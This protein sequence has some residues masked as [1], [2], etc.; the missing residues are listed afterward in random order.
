MKREITL[1]CIPYAGAGFNAYG[2]L[3]RYFSARVAP[4]TLE[5]PGRGMRMVEDLIDDIGALVEDY[6]SRLPA[7]YPGGYALYGHSLGAILACLLAKRI[8]SAGLPAPLRLIV[9]GMNSPSRQRIERKRSELPRE[10]LIAALK[11]YGGTPEEV[12]QDE[13]L[14]DFVEPILRAD[15][16]TLDNF[17]YTPNAP[18]KTPISVAYGTGDKNTEWASLERWKDETAS[19]CDFLEFDGGHFFIFERARE[20]AAYVESK[21]GL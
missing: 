20:F 3:E 17:N 6:F 13:G 15:F 8:E 5:S 11:R 4:L 21:L 7:L 10:D 2:K 9:S 12:F 18:I 14:F 19:G 1:I 16:R